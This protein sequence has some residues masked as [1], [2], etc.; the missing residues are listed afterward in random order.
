MFPNL[1]DDQINEIMDGCATIE[2]CIASIL[3]SKEEG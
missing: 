3:D 1:T 2:E